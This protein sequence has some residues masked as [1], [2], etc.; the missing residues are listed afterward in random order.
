MFPQTIVRLTFLLCFNLLYLQSPFRRLCFQ[1][2]PTVSQFVHSFLIVTHTLLLMLSSFLNYWLIIR[3]YC[4][5]NCSHNVPFSSIIISLWNSL[6]HLS[7]TP[8]SSSLNLPFT[9]YFFLL[10][11]GN[12]HLLTN[13][14]IH[15]SFHFIPINSHILALAINIYTIPFYTTI[16]FANS[17]SNEQQYFYTRIPIMRTENSLTSHSA[18]QYRTLKAASALSCWIIN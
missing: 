2:W 16:L 15:C 10:S 7:Y 17:H 9:I 13:Q 12:T 11:S 8:N 6:V 3:T 14:S 1:Q 5:N 4:S 18:I